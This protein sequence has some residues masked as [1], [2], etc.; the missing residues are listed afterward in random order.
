M[1][2]INIPNEILTR[3]KEL[4]ISNCIIS[5][6]PQKP[7]QLAYRSEKGIKKEFFCDNNMQ[8]SFIVEVFS[9]GKDLKLYVTS[10]S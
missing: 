10:S 4:K 7:I 3:I 1:K 5:K 6:N 2:D 9:N 8:R